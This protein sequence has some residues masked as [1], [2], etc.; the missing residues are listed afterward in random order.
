ME[1]LGNFIIIIIIPI[2]C[3]LTLTQS[4]LF[5]NV[6]NDLISLE[7]IYNYKLSYNNIQFEGLIEKSRGLSLSFPVS[8]TIILEMMETKSAMNEDNNNNYQIIK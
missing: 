2:Y 1:L 8:H 3:V 4:T 7:L 5:D 6:K